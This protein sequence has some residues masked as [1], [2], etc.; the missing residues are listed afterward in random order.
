MRISI[1]AAL[2]LAVVAGVM[3]LFN[4]GHPDAQLMW[5]AASFLL[6]WTTRTRWL[7]LL[8][9]LAVPIAAPFGY[10]N[11]VMI[12]DPLG[13]IWVEV[14]YWAPVHAL[15]V[16]AGCGCRGVYERCRA[17]RTSRAAQIK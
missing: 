10:S 13:P 14:A 9:L 8:P 17:A 6:G 1:V 16:L 3:A 11:A 12:G 7:A 15:I 2:Y 5:L 4:G